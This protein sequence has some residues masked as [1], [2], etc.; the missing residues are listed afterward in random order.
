MDGRQRCFSDKKKGLLMRDIKKEEF[1]VLEEME[2]E[3][4]INEVFHVQYSIGEGWRR[5]SHQMLFIELKDYG[6]YEIG[7]VTLFLKK[8]RYCGPKELMMELVAREE[9][10]EG[11]YLISCY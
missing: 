6:N 10:P 1:Y 7:L 2:L 3:R 8:G 5:N 11:V 9:I 4:I